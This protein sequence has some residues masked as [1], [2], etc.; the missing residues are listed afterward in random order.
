MNFLSP[1]RTGFLL[2]SSMT[3]LSDQLTCAMF[4]VVLVHD[5]LVAEALGLLLAA[6][7]VGT[8]GRVVIGTDSVTLGLG[9]LGGGRRCLLCRAS[10][11][12]LLAGVGGCQT[13]VQTQCHCTDRT[14]DESTVLYFHIFSQVWFKHLKTVCIYNH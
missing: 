14:V 10:I 11:A 2:A 3:Q 9:S 8:D 6:L 13:H 1:R 7:L 12:V 4:A 5:A